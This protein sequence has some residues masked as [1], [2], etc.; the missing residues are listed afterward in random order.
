MSGRGIKGMAATLGLLVAAGDVLSNERGTRFYHRHLK[1]KA[2][3]RKKA[4][5]RQGQASK[6]R[7]RGGR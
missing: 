1:A 7:N 4:K 3:R 5:R 2:G 6:R